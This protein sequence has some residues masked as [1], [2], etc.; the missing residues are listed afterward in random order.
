MKKKEKTVSWY[1]KE[2]D[3]VFSR[4]IR[5]KFAVDGMVKCYTCN[6]L[7]EIKKMQN[8]HCLPRQYLSMRY[9]EKNCRPQCYACNM[10]YGGQ[11]VV[12]LNKL[13][14][15]YGEDFRKELE[16]E[17]WKIT[18]WSIYDYREIIDKYK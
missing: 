5:N 18:K 8:G 12:F 3:A 7:G 14:A 2:A 16:R 6:H 1:K 17:K 4:F 13:C 9:S 10:L 15:E 11:I